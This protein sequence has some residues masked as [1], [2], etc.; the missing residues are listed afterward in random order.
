MDLIVGVQNV[1]GTM[2]VTLALFKTLT[3]FILEEFDKLV[4]QV[5]PTIGAHARSTGELLLS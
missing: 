2:Q 4:F 3:N 1:L 5:V